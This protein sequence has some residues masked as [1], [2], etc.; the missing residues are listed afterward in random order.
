[1]YSNLSPDYGPTRDNGVALG[2]DYTRYLRFVSPSL[3]FR[4]KTAQGSTVDQRTVGGGIKL[5]HPFGRFHPY[6]D[7]LISAGHIGFANKNAH[8]AN[9]TGGNDSV[10]YSYGG[11]VDYDF[12]RKWAARVDFQAENWDLNEIPDVKLSPMVISVGVVYRFRFGRDRF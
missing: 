12:A 4:F 11:G 7:F 6:G 1:M 8:G 3:E 9:G 5:E 2:A 10:V